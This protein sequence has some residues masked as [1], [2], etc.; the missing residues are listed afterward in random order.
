MA[1][2]AGAMSAFFRFP[3]TP[4]LAWLGAGTPRDDKVLAADEAAALLAGEVVVEE[5][6][7]GANLGISLGPDSTLRF[8]NR[9][10]YLHPPYV[11]QF[12]RLEAWSALHQDN[13]CAALTEDQIVFGEW[14]A[15]RHSVQ[16]DRLPDWFIM[17][18]VFNRTADKFASTHRRNALAARVGLAVV[19]TLMRGHTN[20]TALKSRLMQETSRYRV[21]PVEGYVIRR[22]SAEWLTARAKL[23]HPDFVQSIGEHWRRRRIEWNRLDHTAITMKND[24][25]QP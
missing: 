21:G 15:A 19:S 18:D 24:E 20:L 12:Q 9:G 17:F 3:H 6:L 1:G 8:Q 16:Y 11:G 25:I 22:E 14:C 13:L 4:H 23:V 10:Q 5:K 7:D 2:Q